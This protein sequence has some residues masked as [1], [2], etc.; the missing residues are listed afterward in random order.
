MSSDKIKLKDLHRKPKILFVNEASFLRTG[1]STYGWHIIKRLKATGRYEI[2]ELGSYATQNDGRW[3]DPRWGIDWKYYGVMPEPNDQQG[4]QLYK[5]GYHFNQFGQWKFDEV[6]LKEKPD[7]VIDIRDRWMASEWQLK[8]P[9]RKFFTYIYMPCVDSH[10]PMPDWISDYKAVDYILGYSHYAKHVLEREGIKCYGVTN[11]GVD[12]NAFNTNKSR[13]E[14]LERWSLKSNAKPILCVHRNQ[15]RKLMPDMVYAYTILKNENPEAFK[16]TVLWLHT[17]WPDVGFNIP[18]VM[19]RAKTGRI[20]YKDAH[21]KLKEKRYKK[22]LRYADVVFSYICHN[23]KCNHT[24]VS[25]Y[26]NGVVK[27]MNQETGKATQDKLTCELIYCQKCGQKT[28]RMPNT[29]HGFDPKDFADVYRAAWVHVQPAIAGADEMPMN[30]AKACGTP[31]IAPVH[32]AMHEKV[33]KTDYCPDDRYKG[34]MPIKLDSLYTEAET[35]QHRCILNKEHLAKQLAK[36]LSDSKLRQKL[37]KEAVEVTEKYYDWDDIAEQWDELLWDT[38]EIKMPDKTWDAPA[39]LKEYQSYSTETYVNMSD[40]EFVQWCYK[41]FLHIDEPDGPGFQYWMTDISKGRARD[42]IV[43]YFKQQADAHNQKELMR[44]GK[45]IVPSQHKLGDF[46]DSK[47]TFRIL[48]VMPGTAGDLHLL[49]GA[50]SELHKKYN[51][52]DPWGLYVACEPQYNPILKDL[53]FIK[54]LVPYSQNLDNAKAIEKSGLVNIVF[55]P[56]I[57]TQRFEHYVHNGHGKHLAKAYADM[58]GVDLGQPVIVSSKI[59]GLPKSYR[60]TGEVH[61]EIPCEFYVLHCKTSMIS[62]DWPIARFKSVVRL[63]P[64]TQFVQVG[65]PNDPP[66]NEPN[67]LDFRG[68]TSF[69]QMAYVIKKSEGIIGL[70][71][72]ALHIAST[73]GTPSLGIFSATY[74]N[75]CGPI[76]SHGGCIVVPAQR[77]EACAAPCHMRECPSKNDPCITR[78]SVRQVATAMEQIFNES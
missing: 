22:G 78:V 8:S 45:Q 31:V 18:V 48:V 50:L 23:P 46:F 69:N 49:T 1:F 74:P 56:H 75:I 24:F 3:K 33:E 68:K 25:P 41:H 67:V 9:Y 76:N 70:D 29:Q 16:N 40:A 6:L 63:F 21:G 14:A 26:V 55:T 44:T 65:G 59:D 38:V 42:N 64:N 27:V 39:K 19:D 53:P 73:V 34:G 15:K 66:I 71:S 4:Q 11:P 54:N 61:R 12:L 7:I 72:I 5:Q 52:S 47:D 32:A 2:V 62:K 37:S 43:E 51:R 57:I 35:M 13:T 28:A 17:S 10:P 60:D 20:P 58:C 36:I 30:E 77:P